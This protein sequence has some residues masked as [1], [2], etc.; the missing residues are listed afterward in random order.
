M[1]WAD[2]RYFLAVAKAGSLSGAAKAL[3]VNHSTVFRRIQAFEERL[4]VR[5]FDRLP[6]GYA[7][8]VAGDDMLESAARVDAEIDALDR[9]LAGRDLRLGGPLVVTTTATLT[10]WA[11][12]PHFAA[13]KRTHPDVALELV[14]ADEFFN[15]S[16]RQADVAIRPTNAPPENLVGRRIATVAFA[17]YASA[18]YLERRRDSGGPAGHDW[19][20]F[21]D[22]LAHLAAAQWLRKTYPGAAVALRVNTLVGLLS[23][24]VAGMGLTTLPC[25]MGDAEPAL[26]RFGKPD[27]VP[28]SGL[29]LLTHEDL[30][31]TARVRAFMDF[32]ADK[33]AGERKLFEGKRPA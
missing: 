20:A 8:T 16:K 24:A 28:G 32:M 19:V 6:T 25:F 23:A 1:D 3:G 29:W 31:R 11:L 4:G 22:S 33:I 13:F 5:L 2:L 30:R 15:L 18:D 17:V 9:R 26:R 12:A 27:D 21:D 14:L 7:L 10:Y